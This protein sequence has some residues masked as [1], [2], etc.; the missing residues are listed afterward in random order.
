MYISALMFTL[1]F[2]DLFLTSIVH[3]TWRAS[4]D[5]QRHCK[6]P[7]IY[8]YLLAH[9]INAYTNKYISHTHIYIYTYIYFLLIR[10]EII[11]FLKDIQNAE[12][13]KC[14]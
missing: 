14:I 5:F 1:L 2:R 7:R 3:L 4:T 9:P 8:L 13:N 6:T 10:S 12:F 11:I